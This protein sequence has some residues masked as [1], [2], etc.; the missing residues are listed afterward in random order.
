MD[1]ELL[2]KLGLTDSQAR[3]YMVLVDVGSITPP[4]LA[5][6]TGESRT[7]AYMALAKLQEIGLAIQVKDSKKQTYAPTSPSCLDSY[8]EAKRR[9]VVEIEEEY[10]SS[11]SEMLKYYYEKRR[12]TGVQYFSGEEGLRAMYEAHLKTGEDIYLLRTSADEAFF[13]DWLFEYMDRRAEK[14]IKTYAL[15]PFDTSSYNHAKCNDMRLNREITWYPAQMYTAPVEMTAF[16][17]KISIISFGEE[18]VG[19]ILESPQIA[20]AMKE[21]LAMAK[22]GACATDAKLQ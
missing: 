14:G 21:L 9:E 16:G 5:K 15:M 18:V 6:A 19:T 4:Q 7:A 1:I 20:Q 10:R 22:K 17:D 2:K 11:V 13:G 12:Q 3:S 8:I